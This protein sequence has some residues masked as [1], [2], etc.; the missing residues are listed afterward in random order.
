MISKFKLK[1]KKPKLDK[2]NQSTQVLDF[3]LNKT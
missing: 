3:K 2:K 1:P